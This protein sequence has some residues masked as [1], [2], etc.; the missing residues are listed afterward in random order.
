M[1]YR[2]A[3]IFRAA[4]EPELEEMMAPFFDLDVFENFEQFLHELAH[5]QEAKL[6]LLML[7]ERCDADLAIA[8]TRA[9][10]HLHGEAPR[11]HLTVA[12]SRTHARHV[13]EAF[14]GGCDGV[15]PL[16]SNRP[17]FLRAMPA[18]MRNDIQSSPAAAARD[19]Q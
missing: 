12:T 5:T 19:K 13:M 10:M 17:S 3:M 6:V 8:A 4:P 7:G 16:P 14:R 11:H 1:R 2:K 18:A 9:V 15:I